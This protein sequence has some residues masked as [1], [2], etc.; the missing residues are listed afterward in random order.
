MF[1]EINFFSKKNYYLVLYFFSFVYLLPVF[2]NEKPDNNLINLFIIFILH[3]VICFGGYFFVHTP[4][5]L[6]NT[7]IFG[8][9]CLFLIW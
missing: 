9:F 7:W 2:I 8:V 6:N 5:F 1:L 3:W 4:F